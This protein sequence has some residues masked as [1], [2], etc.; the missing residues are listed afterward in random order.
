[1][2]I[3]RMALPRRTFLRGSWCDP[4]AAAA[5]RH[6]SGAH[7]RWPERQANPV[8][9]LGFFYFPNG[10]VDDEPV[11]TGGRRAKLRAVADP[12]RVR[13]GP[14]DRLVVLSGLCQKHG[15]AD[16][17]W[18]RRSLARD[19]DLAERR[20]PEEDGG[21]RCAGPASPRIR[22]RPQCSARTRRSPPSSSASTASSIVGTCENGYSCV[23]MNTLSW[24]TPTTP[25]P[26]EN[27]PRVVFERMFGDGGSSAQRRFQMRNNRSILDSV[28]GELAR[29]QRGLGAPDRATVGDYVDSVREVERRIQRA[30][31]GGR[32]RPR[33][34]IGRSA[35]RDV[36]RA[37]QADVRPAGAGLP[38]RHHPRRDV[39]DGAA[40]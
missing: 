20:A 6:D 18:Q 14:A 10:K 5:R 4:R 19:I 24:R 25:L 38:G 16:G 29:L 27:N 23:Y 33:R 31:R 35:S 17:R 9:R 39:P 37:R 7:R 13:A 8:R 21:R 32:D 30:E 22:S 40:K 34:R 28:T 11:D 2:I 12:E 3:T 15:A 36:R 26:I 1:M